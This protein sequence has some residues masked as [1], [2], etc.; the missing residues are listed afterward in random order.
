[1]NPESFR[2]SRAGRP[3][4]H[5]KG[6]W[7]YQPSPLPPV[8]DWSKL[9]PSSLAE[10][11][12]NLS[13]LATLGGAV[14][15]RFV[16]ARA[17]IRREAVISSH[18]EGTHASLSDLYLYEIKQLSF[19][20]PGSDAREVYNY[21]KA[22]NY[23]LRRLNDL[24]IS[25]RLIREIHAGLLEGVRGEHLTP[26]EF[27]RSQ[28]WIGP[29]GCTLEN[30]PY[31]PPPVEDMLEALGALEGFIHSPSDLPEL[32][33]IGLIHY[34]F[35]AI[36]PFLDGNGRVGRLLVALL[37]C[38][39]GLLPQPHLYLSAYFDANRQEYYDRLLQVS[40]EGDWEGWLN[41]FLSGVS[42]QSADAARRLTRLQALHEAYQRRLASERAAVRLLHALD[43]L[44]EH[45]ILSVNQLE[46][47]LQA[48]YRS[49][50]RYIE[51]FLALGILREITGRE[52]NRLY[53]ADEILRAIEGPM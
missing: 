22:M 1:M 10:A 9:S 47:T 2:T 52:R 53:C 26:G 44:F 16:L 23:G 33:R 43:V 46:A 32:V 24:P 51:K 48:P 29:A 13:K 38:A 8:L 35:E 28:N 40:R 41:F 6:Y 14:P 45:P 7:Y 20:E 3:V 49:A 19:L 18:I 17:F 12:R 39:W 27:R 30:T 34:Q 21:V 36:H 25:L 42:I 37:L 15:A 5:P 4:R 31:V 11:E 50:Q